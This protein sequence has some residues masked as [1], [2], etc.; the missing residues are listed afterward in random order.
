MHKTEARR[1]AFKLRR[2]K[3]LEL[4]A[5]MVVW[6]EPLAQ[7]AEQRVADVVRARGLQLAPDRT[8]LDIDLYIVK[9][10]AA[11]GHT[12]SLCASLTGAVVSSEDALMGKGP[13]VKF[14][15]GLRLR[16][17]L[18]ASEQFATKRPAIL[19]ILRGSCDKPGSQWTLAHNKEEFLALMASRP[20]VLAAALKRSGEEL[21]DD[22]PRRAKQLTREEFIQSLAEFDHSGSCAW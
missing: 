3:P 14:K 22:V 4:H 19:N 6:A 5:G 15:R 16:R 11:R 17:F 18:W 7:E 12:V 13:Y 21:D 9:D 1:R 8:S 2:G 20:K 10:L